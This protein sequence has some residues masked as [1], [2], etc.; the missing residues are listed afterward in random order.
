ME[1][2]SSFAALTTGLVLVLATQVYA[3]T[4]SPEQCQALWNKANGADLG[5]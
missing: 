3:A 2:L 4:V 1:W 5:G